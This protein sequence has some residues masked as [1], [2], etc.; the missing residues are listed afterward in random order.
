M[1]KLERGERVPFIHSDGRVVDLVLKKSDP[2]RA[3][4]IKERADALLHPLLEL[5]TE[6]KRAGF[7]LNF[8]IGYSMNRA[9]LQALKVSKEF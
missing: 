4:E 9:V 3:A 8:S 1:E 2:E 5:M 7:E 6:A